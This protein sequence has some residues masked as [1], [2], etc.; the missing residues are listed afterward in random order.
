MLAEKFAFLVKHRLRNI[1]A[2]FWEKSL[3]LIW[4]LILRRFDFQ[5]NVYCEG[6]FIQ[7]DDKFIL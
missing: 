1:A 5:K 2:I 6:K 7:I 4:V 3:P